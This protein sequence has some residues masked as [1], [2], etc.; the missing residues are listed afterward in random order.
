TQTIVGAA[1]AKTPLRI[2]LVVADQGT[3]AFQL[4]LARFMQT[5]LGHAEFSLTSVIVQPEKIVDFSPDGRVLS[6]G[7]NRLGPRGRERGAQ[8]MEAIEEATKAVRHDARRPVIVVTRL[9]AE[10][11]TPLQGKDVME[12]LR[13]S[14]AILYVVSSAGAQ[15]RAPS[16]NPNPDET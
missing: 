9:G 10:G 15:G 13:K 4:G 14:G 1:E 5:L 16:Q 12:Q 8:L 7:L 3:G 2:A 6:E 11:P